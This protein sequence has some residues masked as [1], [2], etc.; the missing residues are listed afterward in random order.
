M[1]ISGPRRVPS[2]KIDSMEARAC[3]SPG[4]DVFPA[5]ELKTA[6]GEIASIMKTRK[7]MT[8][9]KTDISPSG[10]EGDSELKMTD[11]AMVQIRVEDERNVDAALVTGASR[12]CIDADWWHGKVD[13]CDRVRKSQWVS[14]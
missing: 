9:W 3:T 6:T 11:D 2:G 12:S 1:T 4:R 10:I 14:E 5:K 7:K 8:S 13:N